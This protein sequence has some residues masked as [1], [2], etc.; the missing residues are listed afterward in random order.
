MY[1]LILKK[2]QNDKQP[3]PVNVAIQNYLKFYG[4][5]DILFVL[6]GYQSTTVSRISLF[7]RYMRSII[8]KKNKVYFSNG[9]NG[10]NNAKGSIN[11]IH[12]EHFIKGLIE[13]HT[14][15]KLKDHSKVIF[16]I[17]SDS[18]SDNENMNK[19]SS[20]YVKAVLIGSSNLSCTTYVDQPANKGEMDILLIRDDVI[21]SGSCDSPI[22]FRNIIRD[23][24]KSY[25][26]SPLCCTLSKVLDENEN[27]LNDFLD[28]CRK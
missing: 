12:Y 21:E 9:M 18:L 27:L 7:C 2:D 14:L 19:C 26:N 23:N 11:S 15:S 24:L 5:D 17:K 3:Y 20:L 22:K 6:P 28:F 16:F 1:C 13:P 8:P 10:S 25:D 4:V